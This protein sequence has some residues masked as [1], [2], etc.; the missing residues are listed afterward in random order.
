MVMVQAAAIPQH[1]EAAE[2]RE[3]LALVRELGVGG[4]VL[5]RSELDTIPELLNELQAAAKVPLWVGADV[6]RSLGMRVPA[7]PVSL[8]DAMAIGAIPGADGIAAARFA[9]ELTARESRAAG[10]HWAFAPVADVNVNPANPIINLRSFGE[11]PARVA[12]LVA[13]FVRRGACRR[14]PDDGEALPRTRR[15]RGRQSSRAADRAP[16]IAPVS[17][18]QSSRLSGPRSPP[19]SIRSW[20]GTW[21]CRRS[22]PRRPR[23][24]S[25][26]RSRPGFCATSSASRASSSPMRW[27]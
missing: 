16:A 10:I 13:A 3:L 12:V 4:V 14:R 23:R 24:R 17:S 8:A 20:S 27:T 5:S 1:P 25:R 7:G 15:H 9:G 2:R 22:M 26:R 11:D 18:G 21:P 6:E 19:E